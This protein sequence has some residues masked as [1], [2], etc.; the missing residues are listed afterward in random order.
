MLDRQKFA[1]GQTQG[2]F[3]IPAAGE[4]SFAIS[5]D[6]DVHKSAGHLKS[7]LLGGFEENIPYYLQGSFAV[8]IPFV[9]S[10]PF[11]AAGVVNMTQTA[12]S[13]FD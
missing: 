11:S 12:S 1:S 10:V 13:Q 5:V 9:N 6:L 2:S 7:L 3:T 8:D 4:E